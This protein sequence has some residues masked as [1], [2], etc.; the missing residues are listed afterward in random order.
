[1]GV[2]ISQNER[3]LV[4]EA[5]KDPKAFSAL[6]SLYLQRI[7][8]YVSWRV[9]GRPDVEDLVS[10]I[11]V[12]VLGRLSTFK[13]KRNASFSSWVFRIA[14]NAVI[15]YYRGRTKRNLDNIDDLPEIPAHGS[16]PDTLAERRQLFRL[17]FDEIQ[18]LP[19][20]QA[21]IITMRFFGEM[22]NKEIA[23]ALN[24][25]EKSVSSSLYRG[26]RRLYDRLASSV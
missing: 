8:S 15:D 4:E 25:E 26:L 13:W 11:F 1:M 14:H 20:R 21:E 6:Y 3:T 5:K 16:L 23:I 17:A 18:N 7:Y 24:I 9:G 10:D 12:K 2:N 19:D 22:K